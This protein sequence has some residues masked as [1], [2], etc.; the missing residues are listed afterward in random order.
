MIVLS[1]DQGYCSKNVLD[2]TGLCTLP[3]QNDSVPGEWQQATELSR[4]DD[5]PPDFGPKAIPAQT[6]IVV[7]GASQW[8]ANYNIL[9][10]SQDLSIVKSIARAVSERGNGIKGVEAMAL[11]HDQG[12]IPEQSPAISD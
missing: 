3:G 5:H 4:L 10:Q 9:L 11:K 1:C 12:E 7:I 8:I 2:F 6:G